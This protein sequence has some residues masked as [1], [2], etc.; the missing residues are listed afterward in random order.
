MASPVGF[1]G[2][3]TGSLIERDTAAPPDFL[4]AAVEEINIKDPA[5]AHLV[6]KKIR[7]IQLDSL[8]ADQRSKLGLNIIIAQAVVKSREEE[9]PIR[10]VTKQTQTID[11]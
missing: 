9:R 7:N 1:E 10:M 11:E 6:F 8:S 5:L 2:T 3:R 4:D